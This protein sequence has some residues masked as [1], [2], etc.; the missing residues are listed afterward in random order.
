MVCI[1]VGVEVEARV[2]N[3]CLNVLNVDIVVVFNLLL[4]VNT[5]SGL[6]LRLWSRLADIG[7]LQ[8]CHGDVGLGLSPA[9]NDDFSQETED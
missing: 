1:R 5:S 2:M 3:L 7:L 8:P 9:V 4:E 6:D